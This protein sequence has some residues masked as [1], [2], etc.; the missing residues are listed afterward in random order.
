MAELE[1]TYKILMARNEAWEKEN[2]AGIALYRKVSLSR[3]E[4]G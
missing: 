2:R 3:T 1:R 4:A